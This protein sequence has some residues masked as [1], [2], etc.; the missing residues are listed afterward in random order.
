[1]YYPLIFAIAKDTIKV[2]PKAAAG[3]EDVDGGLVYYKI[4]SIDCSVDSLGKTYIYNV[5]ATSNKLYLVLTVYQTKEKN[6]IE[7]ILTITRNAGYFG[8]LLRCS[9]LQVEIN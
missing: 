4:I 8:R 2:G 9:L 1:L 6:Y 3:Y 7:L 5:Q